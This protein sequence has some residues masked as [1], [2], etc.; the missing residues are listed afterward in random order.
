VI[1]ALAL[2]AA[3]ADPSLLN[4]DGAGPR[5]ALDAELGF[6]APLSHTIQFG[7]Q[8][9]TLDYV[10]EGGQDNLFPFARTSVELGLGARHIVILLYQPLTLRTEVSLDQ[11][12][13][14][15][16]A[17]F[18]AGTPMDLRYG[19][20]FWRGSWMFD[21]AASDEVETGLGLSLQIRNATIDF[22]AAD[23]SERRSYR[24]IGP[25]P[26]LKLRHRRGVGARGFVA[27]EVDGFWAPIRY[28]NG[29]GSDVEGAIVDLSLKG[30]LKLRHGAEAYL[31]L[32]WIGGGAVGT[33][34]TPSTGDGYTRNWLHLATLSIGATLR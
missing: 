16:D 33:D 27:G 14:V 31:A 3:A 6:V 29:S 32:R 2:A 5:V 23:G 15:D 11:E 18:A 26:I 9:T 34:S 1:L 30:G 24:N 10:G 22:T 25:V 13:R 17:V 20:S 28:I 12:L 4:P 21:L 7:Q 19:F 8:G